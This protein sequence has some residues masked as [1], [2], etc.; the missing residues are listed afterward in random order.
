ML[1]SKEAFALI[2]IA[3]STIGLLPYIYYIFKGTVKPHAFTWF[4]WFTVSAIAAAAQYA[5]GGGPGSWVGAVGAA[6]S[7]IIFILAIFKGETNAARSD[8]LSLTAAMLAIPIWIITDNPLYS[9]I[10]VT[11][12]DALGYWPTIRKSYHQPH[13]ELVFTYLMG[14]VKNGL[15]GLA[16]AEFSLTTLVY[17][18]V[19]VIVDIVLIFVLITRRRAIPKPSSN[20]SA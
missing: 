4:I 14:V 11:A 13:S 17:P 12:I 18:V 8:W 3:I 7:L 20:Q 2:G 1:I 9:I 19:I 5:A 10:L 15:S 16:M 6:I